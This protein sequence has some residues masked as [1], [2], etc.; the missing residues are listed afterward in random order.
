[1]ASIKTINYRLE[2]VKK[3]RQKREEIIEKQKTK[4]IATK[5]QK[6]RGV[7]SLS[8]KERENDKSDTRD[9]TNLDYDNNKYLL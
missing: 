4:V 8:S 7:I 1:M 3:E 6:T 9:K 5:Y 2:V